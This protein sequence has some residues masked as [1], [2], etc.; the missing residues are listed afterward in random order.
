[1]KWKEENNRRAEI[2]LL[3]DESGSSWENV[4]TGV[5]QCLL[6]I[7]EAPEV[8]PPEDWDR[9]ICEVWFDSGRIIFLPGK[10]GDVGKPPFIVQFIS[11]FLQ[12]QF[13]LLPDEQQPTFRRELLN[14]RQR[15]FQVYEKA[16]D[17]PRVNHAL[18]DLRKLN[19]CRLFL[20]FGSD[21]DTRQEL[22]IVWQKK[23]NKKAK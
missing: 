5:A 18:Q 23:K 11:S 19:E 15:V 7:C 4:A 6:K 8:M 3:T 21:P 2:H 20:Q 1:M 13:D 16:T 22:L 17:D 10:K 14:M 12:K 9:V